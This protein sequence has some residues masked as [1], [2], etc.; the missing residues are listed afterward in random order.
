[1]MGSGRSPSTPSCSPSSMSGTISF[2]GDPQCVTHVAGQL[3][4]LC[5]RLLTRT[6]ERRSLLA[7]RLFPVDPVHQVMDTRRE[8]KPCNRDHHEPGVQRIKTSKELPRF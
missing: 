7:F 1:M 4:Y 5:P 8:E 3:C 6:R 2:E